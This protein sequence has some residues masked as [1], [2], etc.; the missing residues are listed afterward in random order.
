M[1]LMSDVFP[2]E[3]KQGM[4]TDIKLSGEFL[5]LSVSV[6]SDEISCR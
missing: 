1:Q 5:M 3:P 2:V 6:L 4:G